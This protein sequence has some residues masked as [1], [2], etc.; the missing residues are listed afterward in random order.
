MFSTLVLISLSSI[1]LSINLRAIENL[2]PCSI[3]RS[4]GWYTLSK[5]PTDILLSQ[6]F[7]FCA[8]IRTSGFPRL[9]VTNWVVIPRLSLFPAMPN[10][11][12]NFLVFLAIWCTACMVSTLVFRTATRKYSG[13]FTPCK[14]PP[15]LLLPQLFLISSFWRLVLVIPCW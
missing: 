7:D 12:A 9:M 6:S 1:W 14:M 10:Y 15:C 4:N 5:L 11:L 13:C 8:H 2:L 3:P